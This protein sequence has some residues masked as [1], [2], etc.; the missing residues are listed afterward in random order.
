MTKFRVS[1]RSDLDAG[2]AGDGRSDAPIEVVMEMA[3]V[4]TSI[5]AET[6]GATIFELM[7]RN[8]N[9]KQRR[10]SEALAAPCDWRIQMERTIRQ[11]AQELTQL[12]RTAGHLANLW[13]IWAARNEAQWQG[14]MAW[15]EEREQKWD[16]RNEDDK[17]WGAGIR[18]STAKLMNGVEPGQEGREKDRGVTVGTDGG[19]LEASHHADTTREEGREKR[20]QLQQQP[21]PK[22][23]LKLQPKPQPAPKL[24]SATTH[25]RRWA[26]VPP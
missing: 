1:G 19:G 2:E 9:G 25:V 7:E 5:A 4:A 26:T 15:M 17:L 11:Q 22:L 3:T 13:E 24:K 21:K 12:H 6:A 14:M 20:Q 18:N 23:Q 8:E 10:R 16:A